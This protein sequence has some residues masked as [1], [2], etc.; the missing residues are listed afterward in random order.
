MN[1]TLLA[2]AAASLSPSPSGPAAQQLQQLIRQ[3]A[4]DMSQISFGFAVPAFLAS[5]PVCWVL[6][7]HWKSFV[8]YKC[9]QNPCHPTYRQLTKPTESDIVLSIIL[10]L[11]FSDLLFAFSY[12]LTPFNDA[13]F[14]CTLQGV[15]LQLTG[16]CALLFSGCLSYELWIVIKHILKG[17]SPASKGRD[18]LLVYCLLSCVISILFTVADAFENGFGRTPSS[19]PKE[20]A[21]CW[22]QSQDKFSFFSFYGVATTVFLGVFVC[23]G[24]V[25]YEIVVKI[26]E[27]QD[28]DGSKLIRSLWR[29]F[30]KVGLYPILMAL[31]LI[32]GLIHRLPSLFGT[33]KENSVV[34][35]RNTQTVRYL[36]AAT[37]P[38]LGLIDA[39]I[40]ASGNSHVRERL[41]SC[42]QCHRE[43]GGAED[44]G[45]GG[46]HRSD[47]DE[48]DMLRWSDDDD[49]ENDGD[50]GLLHIQQQHQPPSLE[51]SGG[52]R[53][54]WQLPSSSVKSIDYRM[55]DEESRRVSIDYNPNLQPMRP[56][57]LPN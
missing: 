50:V 55:S 3:Q 12:L 45:S 31:T 57:S 32:P 4:T 54:D 25:I 6:R 52:N 46:W 49:D 41:R 39:I 47:G 2:A 10:C 44:E 19:D 14:I 16:P 56:N 29:T 37:M 22:V 15:L 51:E 30:A 26:K 7:H 36:H 17:E 40:L 42:M 18:R 43:E 28:G 38:L 35:L 33:R 9:C 20:I 13:A 53:E 5:L 11:Q 34:D 8:C 48:I 23:Y 1:Q 27:T 24:L 21:W